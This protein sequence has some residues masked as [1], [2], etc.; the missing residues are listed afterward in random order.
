MDVNIGD[1]V[2][3]DGWPGGIGNNL[4]AGDAYVDSDYPGCQF[5]I[6]TGRPSQESSA[7]NL[8]ITGRTYNYRKFSRPAFRVKIEWVQDGEPNTYSHGWLVP[9]YTN[10]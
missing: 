10:S 5:R 2:V 8:T 3:P 6:P 9:T 7:I 1:Y 4:I